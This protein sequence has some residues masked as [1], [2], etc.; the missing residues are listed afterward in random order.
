MSKGISFGN[1]DSLP[2]T[3]KF[4][5]LAIFHQFMTFAKKQNLQH[6]RGTRVAAMNHSKTNVGSDSVLIT[7]AQTAHPPMQLCCVH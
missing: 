2:A 6:L 3:P 5:Q 1:C 7:T 4:P